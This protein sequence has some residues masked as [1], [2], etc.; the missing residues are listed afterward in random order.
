LRFVDRPLEV[1][2]P[3]MVTR[4]EKTGQWVAP[5]NVTRGHVGAARAF[6]ENKDFADR[7]T[8]R[9]AGRRTAQ[10]CLRLARAKPERYVMKVRT[11]LTDRKGARMLRATLPLRRS[12][13]D[14][15]ADECR[16]RAE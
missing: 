7:A 12:L 4:F 16:R 15:P 13:E 2:L 1:A 11:K 9:I 6:H 3:G 14:R 5:D 8:L 10:A